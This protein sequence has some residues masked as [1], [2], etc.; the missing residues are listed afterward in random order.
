M[1]F[2]AGMDGRRSRFCE[3]H[4]AFRRIVGF[5]RTVGRLR[6]PRFR[7]AMTPVM[8]SKGRL[9]PPAERRHQVRSASGARR[10][11]AIPPQVIPALQAQAARVAR[12]PADHQRVRPR[13]SGNIPRPSTARAWPPPTSSN[14]SMPIRLI[15]GRAERGLSATGS[16]HP[17]P[18]RTI[19]PYKGPR[20]VFRQEPPRRSILARFA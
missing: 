5:G 13:P 8:G 15:G 4:S 19:P 11:N 12:A 16:R 6:S 10:R 1:A 14:G 3:P 7:S 20:H 2:F 17:G 9:S 18:R